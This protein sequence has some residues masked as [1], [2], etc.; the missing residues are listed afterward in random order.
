MTFT[1]TKYLTEAI[2]T[3]TEPNIDNDTAAAPD[4]SDQGEVEGTQK[5]FTNDSQYYEPYANFCRSFKWDNDL[6]YGFR[7]PRVAYI[8]A[9]MRLG[10]HDHEPTAD[11]FNQWIVPS[12]LRF[13]DDVPE[14][15]ASFK[16]FLQSYPQAKYQK[17]A[18]CIVPIEAEK[19][20]MIAR[21]CKAKIAETA[22]HGG[23][24]HFVL[25]DAKHPWD[26]EAVINKKGIV[27]TLVTVKELRYIY[28]NREKLSGHVQFW[29]QGNQINPPWQDNPILW[30]RFKGRKKI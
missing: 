2:D 26:M 8:E 21:S 12:Q 28:K 18:E 11:Y 14:S 7:E 1:T 25:D 30:E 16:R 4:E 17:L 6:I 27:G 24:V 5:K 13:I 22:S 10:E 9:V 15:I 29:K 23:M 3:K 20:T 19:M